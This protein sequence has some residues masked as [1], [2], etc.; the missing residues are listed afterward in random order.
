M[1]GVRVAVD[2]TPLLGER[3][4]IGRYVAGLLDGFA[5]LPDAPD[6]DL[7]AFTRSQARPPIRMGTWSGRRVPARLLHE[8]WR[9][10]PYPP[11]ETLA[12]P[13]DVVHATNFVLPPRRRTAGVASVHDLAFLL[14]A[15]TVTPAVARLRALVPRLLRTADAVITD[16]SAVADLVAE[17][18]P[19]DRSRLHAVPLGVDPAWSRTPAPD[20]AAR[21][22]L[23][24]PSSYVLFVGSRE[25]RKDL[26]TLVRAL[27]LLGSAAPP[28][29]L[30][31]PAGWGPEVDLGGAVRLG[32]LSDEQLRTVVAGADVL[33]LPSR[34]E[35]FGLTA[36]EALACGTAVVASDLPVLREVL[37]DQATYASAG[38]PEA[39]ADAIGKLVGTPESRRAHAAPFTWRACA[40]RTLEVYASVAR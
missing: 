3:T 10:V 12:G 32:Y 39:F 21:G 37:G 7:L 34:D 27:T 31:G 14:H 18:L 40:E 33:A 24:L 9:R 35:G 23:G 38:Q 1:T 11:I 5:A 30:A 19:V 25:P 20:A 6:L 29:V 28:L 4:G 36:L 13:V 2:G 26:G 16:S 15:D 22:A 8:A 17:H